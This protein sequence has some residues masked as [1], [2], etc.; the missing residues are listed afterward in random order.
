[1]TRR[2]RVLL[3]C[4]AA[5]LAA[6]GTVLL[7]SLLGQ[8]P[9]ARA[10]PG[11]RYVSATDPTCGGKSPCHG[12]I[13]EA[14]DAA[15]IGDEILVAAGIYT[16][17]QVRGGVTQVVYVSQTV[18][19]RG[20]HSADFS[21]WNPQAHP[22][23]LDAEGQGRVLY[24]TDSA[25]G[26]TLE[27][28]RITGG[29]ATGVGGGGSSYTPDAGG[30]VCVNRG[31]D[32]TLRSSHIFSNTADYGGGAW[33]YMSRDATLI[34][35]A[36]YSNTADGHA[37]GIGFEYSQSR[38][39]TLTGNRVFSNT[40][41]SSGGG[42]YIFDGDG[43]AITGNEVINNTA[44]NWGGGIYF[45]AS[46]G[47][48]LKNNV[49][50]GNHGA[51]GLYMHQSG[52]SHI[53]HTT[54]ARNTVDYAGVYLSKGAYWLTN[55]ILVS[56]TVGIRV[57]SEATATLAATLWG[58]DTWANDTDWINDGT[59][60]TGTLNWWEEPGFVAPAAGDYHIGAGSGA[61]DRGV[62]AGVGS[63]IDNEP[64]IYGPPDLGADEY[65]PP[66]AL[67]RVYLPLVLRNQQ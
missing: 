14:V 11:I 30:G 42:I 51:S 55:T 65:W 27:G 41:D 49:V 34:G 47:V 16:G 40:S 35:N 64:R 2:Q 67:K 20:G 52:N 28:L 23:T 21:A 45:F 48:T 61:L 6:A 24:L 12:T 39:P 10:D 31:D 36:V 19:I 8:P 5:F 63:D 4:S 17:V 62:E 26:A 46:T 66:G 37:G 57:Q 15:V 9:L 18:T 22:T 60:V 50:A 29:D 33:F 3:A 53:L 1:M 43:G 44:N 7:V 32:I 59:L 13:Q 56:H 25:A 58:S 38:G 54:I